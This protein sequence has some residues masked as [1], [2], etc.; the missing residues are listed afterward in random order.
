VFRWYASYEPGW[1]RNAPTL[2]QLARRVGLPGDALSDTITRFNRFC[3]AGRDEDFRRGE[4]VWERYKVRAGS[5]MVSVAAANPTL[6]PIERPRFVAIPLNRSILGTK[7]G[8]RTDARG[9]VLKENDEVIPGLLCAGNLMANPIGTRAIGAGTT[10]GPV[11][12]WGYICGC[13]LL[14]NREPTG[15]R[16]PSRKRS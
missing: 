14:G 4:S 12:T 9:Q 5:V 11:M 13:T 7:G 15:E 16:V 2:A 6:K 8:P 3:A 10:I 1:V